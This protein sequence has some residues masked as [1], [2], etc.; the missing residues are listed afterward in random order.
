VEVMNLYTKVYFFP[1]HSVIRTCFSEVL[2][3]CVLFVL[4]GS[5]ST[6]SEMETDDKT[7]VSTYS[8]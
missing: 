5:Q 8:L 7:K 1:G 4:T 2:M 3:Q 6:P